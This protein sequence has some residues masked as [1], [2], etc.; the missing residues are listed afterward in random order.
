[1]FRLSNLH[2]RVALWRAATNIGP[3]PVLVRAKDSGAWQDFWRTEDSEA[4]FRDYAKGSPLRDWLAAKCAALGSSSVL[5]LGCNVGANLHAFW[6]ADKNVKLYGIELN[7]NAVAWGKKHMPEGCEAGLMTGS[8]ADLEGVLARNGVDTIDTV[9]S[10]GA[11]MHVNDEIFA[12]AK[13]QALKVARKAIVHL[14]YHAWTPAELQNGRNWRSSFLS[15]RW[16]RDYV[17]EY[18]SMPGVTRIEYFR[19]PPEINV[20]RN[21]GRLMINDMT[22]LIVAHRQ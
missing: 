10:C 5:E 7:E 17:A 20:A 1:V 3:L 18:E 9:F 16:V 15:D 2:P 11:T 4:V 12:A 22:G 13:Q 8:M 14:E 6:R 21:I 19:I